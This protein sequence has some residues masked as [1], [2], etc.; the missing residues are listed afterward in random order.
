DRL[1]DRLAQLRLRE[2][3]LW[4]V[5]AF[6]RD[7]VDQSDLVPAGGDGPELVESCDRGARDLGEAVLEL[8]GRDPDL[9][10][11]L[12]VARSPP[13]LRLELAHGALDLACA[14]PDRA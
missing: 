6:V 3:A 4:V 14:R 11:D 13:E 12:L 7:R 5:A 9:A 8:V 2:R 10:G 1:A